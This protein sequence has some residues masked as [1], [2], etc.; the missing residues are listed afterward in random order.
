MRC[1]GSDAGLLHQPPVRIHVEH[2]LIARL[3]GSGGW[4][5]GRD[6]PH[7]PRSGAVEHSGEGSGGGWGGGNGEAEEAGARR[8]GAESRREERCKGVGV[9]TTSSPAAAGMARSKDGV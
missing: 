7:T 5:V 8:D 9:G 4:R 3:S 1:T 2:L 6:S